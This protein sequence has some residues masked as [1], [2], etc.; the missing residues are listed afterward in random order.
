MKK[1]TKAIFDE[2]YRFREARG[3]GLVNCVT[4]NTMTGGANDKEG[5]AF[6]EHEERF[7]RIKIAEYFEGYFGEKGTSHNI[8]S[9]CVCDSYNS[10]PL[11]EGVEKTILPEKHAILLGTQYRDPYHADVNCP[12]VIEELRMEGEGGAVGLK[13]AEVGI[14]DLSEMVPGETI[15]DICDMPC[16]E[17]K[18][19]F[20]ISMGSDYRRRAGL[21]P[22]GTEPKIWVRNGIVNHGK[23]FAMSLE[24]S[25]AVF[26]LEK[27]NS[28]EFGGIHKKISAVSDHLNS[29]CN[30]LGSRPL[31]EVVNPVWFS[32]YHHILEDSLVGPDS[33]AD[34]W[35]YDERLFDI[36]KG[37]GRPLNELEKIPEGLIPCMDTNKVFRSAQ[38]HC[39]RYFSGRFFLYGIVKSIVDKNLLSKGVNH[40]IEVG[41]VSYHGYEHMWGEF[42]KGFDGLASFHEE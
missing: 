11:P 25:E 1:L 33:N 14:I 37:L 42:G 15:R 24:K 38:S 18:L 35:A 10:K 26:D 30:R 17:S 27:F 13:K 6:C 20:Q 41:A 3:E 23:K 7:K 8:A 36:K 28:S 2:K 40:F 16:C 34:F 21:K 4:C 32:P 19:P 12:Y 31:S 29:H 22:D 39:E 9:K 5:T